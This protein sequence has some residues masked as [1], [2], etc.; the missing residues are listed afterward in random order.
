MLRQVS[1]HIRDRLKYR[2]A[3]DH[4]NDQTE[5]HECFHR[6]LRVRW[7]GEGWLSRP[8]AVS[9]RTRPE[10]SIL[11]FVCNRYLGPIEAPYK[12]AQDCPKTDHSKIGRAMNKDV[13]TGDMQ[14]EAI[15]RPRRS[16]FGTAA[17]TIAAA[18]FGAIAF[19]AAQSG[20]PAPKV[21]AIK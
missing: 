15:D 19:A 18:Q 16:F 20:E 2:A 13:L 10:C 14:T 1:R 4:A 8:A 21:A 6:P 17:M 9:K 12:V 5:H 11:R 7:T 3:A